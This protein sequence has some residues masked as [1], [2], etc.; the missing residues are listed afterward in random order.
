MASDAIVRIPEPSIFLSASVPFEGRG[1]YIQTASPARIR[2]AILALVS[3]SLDRF[4]LVFGGHPAIT[5]LIWN[6]ASTLGKERKVFIFQSARF[7]DTILDEARQFNNFVWTPKGG[8]RAESLNIFREWMLNPE[9]GYAPRYEYAVF[10]GGMEG[11]E[12][13]YNIIRKYQPEVKI[14]PVA[15]TGGAALKL[16]QRGELIF[17]KEVLLDEKNYRKVFRLLMA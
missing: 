10:I 9:K 1:D 14:M 6:S 16:V 8:S 15:S 13:E 5:P 12:D 7:E 2:E 4:N 3:K 11:V 17:N